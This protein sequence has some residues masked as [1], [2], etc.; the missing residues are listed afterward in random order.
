MNRNPRGRRRR[1]LTAAAAAGALLGAL[2]L[3]AACGSS[4]RSETASTTDP[5]QA[6][7]KFAQC[8]R[9]NGVP[10][11]P[12][13]DSEGRFRGVGHERQ[14][15]PKFQAAFEACQEKLPGGGHQR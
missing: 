5:Q 7:I 6:L 9:D 8:M 4:S 10:D 12:D 1:F 13:P 11:F 14:D 3:V 15:D 2:T